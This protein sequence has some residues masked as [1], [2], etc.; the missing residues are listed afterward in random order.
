MAAGQGFYPYPQ[1]DAEYGPVKLDVRGDIAVVWIDNPPANSLGPATIEGL[2]ARVGRP[3]R[4]RC[5]GDG[6]GIGEPGAV[7]R[8][9]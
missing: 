3:G 4:A 5:P 6:A 1:V 7:L 8:G 9:R 2:A